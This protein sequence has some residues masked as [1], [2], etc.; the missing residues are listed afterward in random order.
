MNT[1]AEKNISTKQS[2][3]SEETRLQTENVFEERKSHSEKTPGKRSQ[4]VDRG[5]L[6]LL[7]FRFTKPDRLLKPAEFKLVYSKGRKI[8]GRFLNIFLLPNNRENHRVGITASKKGIGNAVQRNRARRL[9]REAF[10]L[11]KPELLL[12]K[13][14]YDFVI[15]CK[16]SLLKV[17]LEKP[18]SEFRFLIEKIGQSEPKDKDASNKPE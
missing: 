16:R 11:S 6:Q 8:D 5:T 12:L 14:K 10:R 3:Q 4:T 18:L 2:P 1:N 13:N 15:N 7:D 9:I 17:K